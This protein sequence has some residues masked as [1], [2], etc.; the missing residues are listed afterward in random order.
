MDIYEIVQLQDGINLVILLLLPPWLFY[1]FRATGLLLGSLYLWML[2]TCAEEGAPSRVHMHLWMPYMQYWWAWGW[3]LALGYL[4]VWYGVAWLFRAFW[5]ALP[6][7]P[8]ADPAPQVTDTPT[9]WTPPHFNSFH[10]LERIGLL[11]S[12]AYLVLLWII[13]PFLP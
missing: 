4:L 2:V 5:R 12:V 7:P 3:L 13:P 1:R 10:P 8:A 11:F 6:R 9:R